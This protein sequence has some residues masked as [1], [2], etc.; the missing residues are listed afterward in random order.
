MPGSSWR[1]IEK[2]ADAICCEAGQ[3]GAHALV[4]ASHGIS[5]LLSMIVGSVTGAVMAR[6]RCPVLVLKSRS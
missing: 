2:V 5:S 1:A 4:I 6:C 3:F